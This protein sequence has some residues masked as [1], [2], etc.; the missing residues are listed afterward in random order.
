METYINLDTVVEDEIFH[1]FQESLIC[2]LCLNILIAPIICMKCQK[3]YC[4]KC[5]EKWSKNNY[6]CPNNCNPPHYQNCIGKKEI[7]FALK[8][9][10]KRCGNPI[11]YNEAK[12]H[13][14]ICYPEKINVKIAESDNQNFIQKMEKISY[15]EAESLKKKGIKIKNI[16]SKNNKLIAF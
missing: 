14:N 4:R 5:I 16:T 12:T 6:Q 13:H 1:L 9:K 15:E 7:L 3:V 11:N 2:P 10:C 8:F